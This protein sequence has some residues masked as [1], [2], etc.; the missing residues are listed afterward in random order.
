MEQRET[1][2]ET[3]ADVKMLAIHLPKSLNRLLTQLSAKVLVGSLSIFLFISTVEIC[4][5]S[6]LAKAASRKSEKKSP[7]LAQKS[8]P[9]P[10]TKLSTEAQ[11]KNKKTS[12]FTALVE[13]EY[14][15]NNYKT[16][17]TQ[18]QASVSLALAPQYQFNDMFSIN[19][20]QI[21]S[22]EQ[23]KQRNTSA[24]N[25]LVTGRYKSLAWGTRGDFRHELTGIVPVNSLA[26][27]RDRFQGGLRIG[28]GIQQEWGFFFLK[29]LFTVTRNFH[30]FALNQE[31]SSNLQYS[32]G[33]RVDFEF[34]LSSSIKLSLTGAYRTGYTYRD[35]QRSNYLAE[36][37]L[38]FSPTERTG[39]FVG[40]STDA[41]VLKSNGQ[42]TNI[43]FFDENRGQVQAGVNFVF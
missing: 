22:Q 42:E 26:K 2:K 27:E 30:E 40:L 17:D 37:R 12:A 34:S 16:D 32:V 11:V 10:S 8:L 39:V 15:T 7:K 9:S 3:H 35:F 33:H 6:H 21:V 13:M 24:S 1:M 5:F 31:G 19:L 18:K 25:T 38:D 23:T 28:N 36:S 20:L 4:A 29:Y 41:P 43:Q 14:S